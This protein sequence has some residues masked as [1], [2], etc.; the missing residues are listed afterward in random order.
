MFTLPILASERCPLFMAGEEVHITVQ[1]A[2]VEFGSLNMRFDRLS[3]LCVWWYI[4]GWRNPFA[5]SS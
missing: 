5:V 1:L 2:R 3:G 4:E